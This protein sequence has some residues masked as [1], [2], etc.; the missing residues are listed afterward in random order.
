MTS[1]SNLHLPLFPTLCTA[2]TQLV[3]DDDDGIAQI[4]D[5]TVID[6]AGRGQFGTVKIAIKEP[7]DETVYAIKVVPKRKVRPHR[8]SSMMPCSPTSSSLGSSGSTKLEDILSNSHTTPPVASPP[9]RTE[10]ADGTRREI[11]VM[12][13]LRH[14]NIVHLFEVID[15]PDDPN[16]YPVMPYCDRGPIV[17]LS[18][19]GTCVPLDID[20]ARGFM[21]QI[22]AGLAYLHS[23]R[24]AHMDVKPDNI[25]LDSTHR[26]YLSDFG[27]S[28][29][30]T[31]GD[32]TSRGLQGTLAFA[33]PETLGAA[34][35]N[36]FLA[37]I[38]ALGVTLYAILFGR[39]PFKGETLTLLTASIARDEILYHPL[40]EDRE[41]ADYAEAIDLLQLMLDRNPAGRPPASAIRQHPFLAASRTSASSGA[42][43]MRKIHDAAACAEKPNPAAAASP[44]QPSKAREGSYTR[45]LPP[46][47][48]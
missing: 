16:L 4:N 44:T 20:I 1:T 12:M 13:A 6:E 27:T 35:F 23:H 9:I 8:A 25:L 24:V 18:P 28:D 3:E 43:R 10:L 37:D 19:A 17:K 15:D 36:P 2:K 29:F 14:R 7:P 48:Q 41:D 11:E 32:S 45:A 21:R 22:T 5:Y 30:F 39:L 34:S 31:G 26:V 38:W 46:T 33:A 40:P 47:H 42:P